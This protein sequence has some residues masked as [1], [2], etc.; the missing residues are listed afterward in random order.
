MSGGH[1]PC[2]AH[3]M[4]PDRTVYHVMP[5]PYGERWLVTEE[6]T[7]FREE[8]ETRTAAIEAAKARARHAEPAQVKVHR[9]DG[10]TEFEDTFDNS[11]PSV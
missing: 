1:A 6:H 11:P 10:S 5:D 2:Y 7:E 9:K 3:G 4:T 8:Y